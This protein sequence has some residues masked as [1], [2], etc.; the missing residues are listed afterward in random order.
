M[1]KINH[2]KIAEVLDMYYECPVPLI[3][4]VNALD[5]SF[6]TIIN[7]DVDSEVAEIVKDKLQSNN[8]DAVVIIGAGRRVNN[9][10]QAIFKSGIKAD[11]T[12]EDIMACHL[13]LYIN[14]KGKIRLFRCPSLPASLEFDLS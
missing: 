5:A 10:V 12:K 3:P 13:S 6:I 7:L 4:I 8:S 14:E 1:R 11:I 2:E 9:K